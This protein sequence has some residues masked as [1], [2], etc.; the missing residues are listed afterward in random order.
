MLVVFKHYKGAYFWS[1]LITSL[2]IIV[3]QFG[4]WGKLVSISKYNFFPVSFTTWGWVVMVVGQSVVLWS[5]LHLITQN[6]RLL[7]GILWGIIINSFVMCTPTIVLTYGSNTAD[8]QHYV[9][10][11]SVMERIQMTAFS[12]QELFISGVYLWEVRRLLKVVDQARMR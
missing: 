7:K 8:V 4:A 10:A 6:E 12:V 11:Y 9:H 2:A 1:L 5:R 3:Y